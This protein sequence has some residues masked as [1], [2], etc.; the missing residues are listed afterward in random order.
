MT[1]DEKVGEEELKRARIEGLRQ[2]ATEVEAKR[3][4]FLKKVDKEL[5]EKGLDLTPKEES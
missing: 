4:A 3:R 5:A 1:W 2:V